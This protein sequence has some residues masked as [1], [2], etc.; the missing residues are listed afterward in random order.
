VA[1][2]VQFSPQLNEENKVAPYHFLDMDWRALL[3]IVDAAWCRFRTSDKRC[4]HSTLRRTMTQTHQNK[5]FPTDNQQTRFI[6]VATL[7]GICVD[8][9]V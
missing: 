5:Y 6:R 1:D 7:A 2:S 3:A 4:D 8:W 9:N